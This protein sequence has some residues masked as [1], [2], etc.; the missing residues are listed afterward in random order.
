MTSSARTH[1][2]YRLCKTEHCLK[3]AEKGK[4]ECRECR[5]KKEA[6]AVRERRECGQ[7]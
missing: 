3:W 1:H 2:E 4:E 7:F 6:R 5:E